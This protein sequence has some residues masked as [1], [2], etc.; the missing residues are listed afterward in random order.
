MASASESVERLAFRVTDRDSF[1]AFVR[2][3]IED[4]RDS[5][6]REAARPSSPYGPDAYGWEHVSIEAFRSAA[7]AWTED[8]RLGQAHGLD[9][10]PSWRTF[11]PFLSAGNGYE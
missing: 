6:A 10:E 4:R 1:L 5:P 2:A 3:L 11:A 9:R 8:A 7:L